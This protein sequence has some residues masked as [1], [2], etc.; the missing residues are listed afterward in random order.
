MG[1]Y[2]GLAK[3]AHVRDYAR[4]VCDALGR[5]VANQA[6]A[7]LV[8]TAAQETHC[9]RYRDPTPNGAGRG[10]TQIDLIAFQDVQRRTRP[11]DAMA[12]QE[13]FGVDIQRVRHDDLDFS[14]ML[15]MIW[16]RLFYKLI[17]EPFPDTVEGRAL[18]YKKYYNTSLGKATP[19][20]YVDN[21]KE[22]G[23]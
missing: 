18:Y 8:E 7:M 16:C 22:F 6:I 2:Y 12:V 21:A 10:L 19:N 11:K 9:G 20:E 13:W 23:V 4:R 15:A 14:P 3:P 5:G 17:P 1:C